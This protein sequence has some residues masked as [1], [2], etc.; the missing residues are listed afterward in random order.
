MTTLHSM[1]Q[2]RHDNF[3]SNI[4]T[5]PHDSN[6]YNAKSNTDATKYEPKMKLNMEL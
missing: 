5:V 3:T 6:D 2:Y 1:S 4:Q